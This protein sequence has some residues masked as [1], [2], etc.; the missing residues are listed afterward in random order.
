M[1]SLVV[2]LVF[3]LAMGCAEKHYHIQTTPVS[4]KATMGEYFLAFVADH[5]GHLFSKME[6]DVWIDQVGE[7]QFPSWTLSEQL[8]FF[9][10]VAERADAGATSALF[11]LAKKNNLQNLLRHTLMFEGDNTSDMKLKSKYRRM[12]EAIERE[13]GK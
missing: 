1:R 2:L 5:R 4:F 7:N 6:E 10:V 11:R 3:L 13:M 9:V 8:D 12:G